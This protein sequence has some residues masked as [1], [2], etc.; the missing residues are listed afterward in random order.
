M[1][2]ES[3]QSRCKRCGRG[4]TPKEPDQEYGPVCARKIGEMQNKGQLFIA[5]D[6]V[7]I[8]SE[9]G[10]LCRRCGT[11]ISEDPH[12]LYCS[13]CEDETGIHDRLESRHTV[14]V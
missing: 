1:I 12:A 5:P 11:D 6:G 2:T 4:F 8:K 14:I 13:E 3:G 10:N 7:M 9:G